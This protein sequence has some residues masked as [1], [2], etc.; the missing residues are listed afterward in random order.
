GL[1]QHAAIE[2]RQRLR[3]PQRIDE[4]GHAAGWPATRDAE[5]DP[6]FVQTQD[7]L[8]CALCQHL[9][10][11]NQRSI[12]IRYYHPDGLSRESIFRCH[13]LTSFASIR[14]SCPGLSAVYK[15]NSC[16]FATAPGSSTT[17]RRRRRTLIP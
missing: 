7:R 12:D 4:H 17:N 11:R 16:R 5:L 10:L 9:L 1:N 13:L 6:R 15:S 2:C 14:L 3:K 8:G